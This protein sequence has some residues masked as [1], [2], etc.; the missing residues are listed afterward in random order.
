MISHGCI[1]RFKFK[2]ARMKTIDIHK[3]FTESLRLMEANKFR[4]DTSLRSSCP[5]LKFTYVCKGKREVP[6]QTKVLLET[7]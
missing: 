4:I 2:N 3:N 1:M 7:G 6:L 5:E